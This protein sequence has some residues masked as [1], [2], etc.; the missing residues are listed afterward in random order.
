MF[1]RSAL[2]LVVLASVCVAFPTAMEGYW[3]GEPEFTPLGPWNTMFNFTILPV[4]GTNNQWLLSDHFADDG[5]LIPG[6]DQQWWAV[7]GEGM[8][9]CGAVYNFFHVPG[10]VNQNFTENSSSDNHI[11][12]CR[13]GCGELEW[14]LKLIDENTLSSH[15]YYANPVNHLNVTFTRVNSYKNLAKSI[16]MRAPC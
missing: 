14:T 3:Q 5:T 16:P 2:V 12:W 9:Y 1:S 4:E 13:D 7:D 15:F 6:T 8:T 10:T 11:Q